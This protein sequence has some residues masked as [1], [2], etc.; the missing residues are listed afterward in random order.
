MADRDE[1]AWEGNAPTA[2]GRWDSGDESEVGILAQID[3][4]LVHSP[5]TDFVEGVMA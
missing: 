2:D 1:R 3:E 5:L 4:H